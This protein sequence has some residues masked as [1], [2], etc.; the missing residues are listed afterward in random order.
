MAVN[1]QTRFEQC[2]NKLSE[3]DNPMVAEICKLGFPEESDLIPTAAVMWDEIKKKVKFLFNKEFQETLTDEEFAF[4]VAH[5]AIHLINGHITLIK[6]HIDEMKKLERTKEDIHKF[7]KKINIAADCV[8]NDSLVEYYGFKPIMVPQPGEPPKIVYGKDWVNQSCHNLTVM[9]VYYM[10]KDEDMEKFNQEQNIDEHFWDSFFNEKGKMKDDVVKKLKDFVKKNIQNSTLSDQ[11]LE[12]VEKL[13]K[14]IDKYKDTNAVYAGTDRVGE[15]RA[16]DNLSKV[17]LNWHK[18]FFQLTE[19]KKQEN[20]WHRPSRKLISVYPDVILPS[21]EYEEKEDIF[22]A[23]DASASINYDAL[24]LFISLIKNVPK[25]FRIKAIS[26]DT[27]CYPYDVMSTERPRGGGG[28][29]FQIIEDW[30]LQNEKK[31]PKLVLVLTD[32][33][34]TN[35][36]PQKPDRWCFA[37]YGISQTK[38][39]KN[40]NR[41]YLEDLLK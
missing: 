16:I 1:L 14:E 9:E 23:I 40:M 26:F 4:I 24:T 11:E 31:Y 15:Y 20:V 41:F 6:K 2:L 37:L 17:S 34:G 27:A 39:C 10:I 28:T 13:K 19:R 29:N 32:G 3:E 22:V 36:T 25:S 21:L 38:Y 35:V 7:L 18:I 8:V 12:R 33:E 30:I 5:E